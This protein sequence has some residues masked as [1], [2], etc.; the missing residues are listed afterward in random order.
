M[1]S[2]LGRFLSRDPMSEWSDKLNYGNAYA[3]GAQC[4][5]NHTDWSGLQSTT[6]GAVGVGVA[7]A[8]A[9]ALVGSVVTHTATTTTVVATTATAVPAA[10]PTIAMMSA[11]VGVVTEMGV[12]AALTVAETVLVGSV[13]IGAAA[14]I[15][16]GRQAAIGVFGES[17]PKAPTMTPEMA[18]AIDEDIQQRR[19]LEDGEVLVRFGRNWEGEND[20]TDQSGNVRPGLGS[21]ARGA[22]ANGFPDGVSVWEFKAAARRFPQKM[23]EADLCISTRKK[24]EGAG[25]E[26]KRTGSKDGHFTVGFRKPIDMAQVIAFNTAF[27]RLLADGK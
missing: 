13:V 19:D 10:G 24:L 15:W 14:G 3:Y 2:R 4:P 25:F 5:T 17:V 16:I 18:K 27:A 21:Q 6:R 11:Q 23:L 12:G 22:E 9:T 7:V 20:T 26:V 1:S 8:G